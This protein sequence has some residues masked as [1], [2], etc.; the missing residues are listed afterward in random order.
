MGRLSAQPRRA[1][2]FAH[3]TYNT[4]PDG[5]GIGF[6]TRLRPILTMRPGFLTFDDARGSGLRHFPADSHIT[7]WLE[8]KG[9]AFDVITDE[10]LDAEGLPLLAG[11]KAVVTGAHPEYHSQVMLDALQNYVGGGGRLAYLGGNGFYWKVARRAD[12][13]G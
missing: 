8:A 10:D 11:Y 7:D 2:E 3:S 4:H 12:L 9:I 6:S 5:S 13:P 1:F